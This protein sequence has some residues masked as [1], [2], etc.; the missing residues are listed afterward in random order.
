MLSG[1]LRR[2]RPV[3]V[4]GLM[5]VVCPWC[6]FTAG[7]MCNRAVVK[8]TSVFRSD[9]VDMRDNDTEWVS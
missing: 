5:E 2:P 9:N 4:V 8:T 3:K 1:H 6:E 7:D